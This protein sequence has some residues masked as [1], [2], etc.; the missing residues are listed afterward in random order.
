MVC[1]RERVPAVIAAA[2]SAH[3]Y[4]EPL[5]SAADILIARNAAS[6]GMVSEIPQATSL[7]DLASLAEK[8]FRSAPRVWGDPSTVLK[9]AATTTGSGSSLVSSAI[10]AGV[11]VL[12]AGEVRYHDA[13]SALES[14]LTV[15]ELGHDVSEWPLV[16]LL[17]KTVRAVPGITGDMVRV[18][19]DK[20][21]WW[22]P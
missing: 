3:P 5:V 10:D 21:N 6:L 4:E 8:A 13:L 19:P 11:D 2:R 1:P 22:I 12:V 16:W 14:G 15:L 20:P 17:E 18:L 7:K 9:T